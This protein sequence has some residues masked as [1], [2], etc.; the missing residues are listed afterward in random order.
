MR[1]KMTLR[2][3]RGSHAHFIA[4]V[5]PASKDF[6]STSKVCAACGKT[7]S[8]IALACSCGH[9]YGRPVR[10]DARP[11]VRASDAA[12]SPRSILKPEDQR[13]IRRFVQNIDLPLLLLSPAVSAF[14]L[15]YS[16]PPLA[17]WLFYLGGV[18]FVAAL[19]MNHRKH[20]RK[21]ELS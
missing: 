7:G 11:A 18:G 5:R 2:E 4:N 9:V 14:G 21:R 13:L 16:E 10:P 3:R 6:M 17:I 20:K 8:D 12:A 15:V 19:I 1:S